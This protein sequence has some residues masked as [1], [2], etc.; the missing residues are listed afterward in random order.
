MFGC[1]GRWVVVWALAGVSLAAQEPYRKAPREIQAVLDAPETPAIFVSPSGDYALLAE[2]LRYPPIAELAQPMLRLAGVRIN[3]MTNGPHRPLTYTSF[4]LMR[5]ADGT[6]IPMRAPGNRLS[7]PEWSPDGA[8][9]AFTLTR[10][11]GIE[12]WAG[13]TRTAAV[14]RMSGVA[15]N[16]AL[17]SILAWLPDS[18]SLLVAAVPAD[19]GRPPVKPEA[20]PG[21]VVQ[22]SRGGAGPLR[23]YQ[24]LLQDAHDEAL[25]DYYATSRLLLVDTVSGRVE[26]L[27][28]P[29][30]IVSAAPSPGGRYILVTRLERPYSYLHPHDR[31]PRSIELWSRT[32]SLIRELARLPL[33]DK[34]PIEG[35]PVGPRLYRWHPIEPATLFWVEAL[36]GG[37]PRTKVP[38][39]DRILELKEPFTGEPREFARLEHRFDSMAWLDDG[40]AALLSDYDRGRR[41]RR[42]FLTDRQDNQRKLL[43]SR[44]IQDRYGDPGTPVERVV[45]SGHRAVRTHAGRLLLA[46]PGAS[47]EG[48]RPFLD[49]FDPASGARER[50]FLCDAA[51]YEQVIAVLDEEGKRLVTRRETPATP[52]NFLLRDVSTGS[53]VPLTD[54]R[55]PAPQLQ[56]ITKRLV[57]YKRADGVP[58]SFMLYLPPGYTGGERLPAVLWAYP[59]EHTSADTAGQVTGSPHRYTLITGASHLFFLLAGYAILDGASMPVIGD[60]ETVNNTFVEQIVAGARAAVEE[61]DRLGVVDRGRVGVGGHSYGAFMTA[62]LLAHSDLFRAGIARSGAYNR[63][64]TPFGFQA[65]RRTLWE[66]P[67]TYVR[68]SPFF[69]AHRINEPLLLIHGAADNN[70]GTFPMQSER[71]YQAVRGNGGVVRLVMLPHES[72]AYVARESVEHAIAEMIDWFD[73]H[74]KAAQQ[75][76]DWSGRR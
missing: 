33:A 54:L 14:R 72:H 62:N 71:M 12:L 34:V 52:P 59:R 9:F 47:P 17:A 30:L 74:V 40:Q 19:R 7:A 51:S 44:N 48:D 70:E 3:P 65:E 36:D 4:T 18:R 10:P 41:W 37:D 68:L 43:F 13:D 11:D 1:R 5:L 50:L 15:V 25:F 39:R 49:R 2:R 66:A 6:R 16:A 56:G 76:L 8:R 53:A 29:G 45:S 58:L 42:T 55:D 22:E 57:T 63:T 60:P 24:D 21:P 69:V 31:F 26:R 61:A 64:L 23:T 73:R 67:E 27:G 20:P 75:K 38:H 35:V 46:G 32:G 28:K